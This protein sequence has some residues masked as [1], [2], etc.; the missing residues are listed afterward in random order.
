MAVINEEV[1]VKPLVYKKEIHSLITDAQ[2]GQVE[3]SRTWR[4]DT[5]SKIG[6]RK[7]FAVLFTLLLLV[8]NIFV[9]WIV[10]K[11][12]F[13][14]IEGLK[15]EDVQVL[16]SVL[17]TGTIGQTVSIIWLMVKWVFSDIDYKN[18]PST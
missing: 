14:T 2:Q 11:S 6:F 10:Y 13:F 16:L 18:R 4:H 3:A 5:E 15:I 8:Q 12:F 17:V 9:Y 7:F 1:G